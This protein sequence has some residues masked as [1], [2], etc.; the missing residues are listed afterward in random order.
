MDI[1]KQRNVTQRSTFVQILL[2]LIVNFS[3]LSPSM[4]LGFSAV[5]LPYLLDAS[6]PHRLTEDEASWFASIASVAAP[7]G[8]FLSGPISDR[9]GRKPAIQSVNVFC[10]LGWTAITFAYYSPGHQYR[11][12]LVGR[13]FTGLSTGL[14]SMPATVYMAEISTAK[15][16]G[17]LITWNALCFSLG[18]V[19]IYILGWTM[20]SNWGMIAALSGAFPCANVVMVM[21]YMVESPSWLITKNRHEDAKASLLRLFNSKSHPLEIREEIETLTC[22]TR[23]TKADHQLRYFTEPAIYRP[24][25][26]MSAFFVFQQ[27]SGTFVIVFYAIDIV[28][29]AQISIDPYLAIVIIAATRS[30]A[31]VIVSV[32]SRRLG[33]RPLS[34][35][36]GV[37]MTLCMVMLSAYVACVQ[38]KII[39][40]H[41]W[42]PLTLLMAYFFTATLGFLTIPF[43]MS[44]EVFPS[45]IRGLATGMVSSMGYICCFVMVKI[46][47]DMLSVMG[48]YP[49][50]IF[51]AAM[52]AIGTI[53]VM[54]CLPETKG[55]TLSEI[56]SYFS[57]QKP[58][59][60]LVALA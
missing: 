47:P 57:V 60:E 40:H 38:R 27:V 46:Y 51:Y 58:G 3:S 13:F 26:L 44:A 11:L 8:C 22:D 14:S 7:L 6:N 59:T 10:L 37:G 33:R 30:V 5:A 12:L 16:R 28:N 52:S 20:T 49:L 4:S 56:E 32:A 2:G 39:D 21:I 50:F 1:Q 53:F 25:I 54:L 31:S 19:V 34:I 36:S 55:R 23:R 24:F 35:T 15:L 17:M 45:T 18:V 29:E 42:L 9:F 48:I 41:D 43:A